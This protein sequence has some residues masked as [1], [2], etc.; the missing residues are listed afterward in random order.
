MLSNILDNLPATS[1]AISRLVIHSDFIIAPVAERPSSH[2]SIY[3]SK[4]LC[5]FLTSPS[6]PINSPFLIAS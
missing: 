4:A 1:V 3:S 6:I 2:L 5:K